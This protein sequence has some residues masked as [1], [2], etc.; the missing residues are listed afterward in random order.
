MSVKWTEGGATLSEDL[1]YRYSLDRVWDETRARLCWVM[2][3]PSTADGREDD[4][5][6]RKCMGFAD[7]WGYGSI[8]VVNLFAY[9]ATKPADLWR[10]SGTIDLVGPDNDR[11]IADA[12][13]K[14]KDVAVA[15]GGASHRIALQRIKS[16]C[17]GPLADTPL[18]CISENGDRSPTH[19]C[20]AGYKD[21]AG[22]GFRV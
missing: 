4:P 15:W 11:T 14:S 5:T 16:L 21:P 8:I 7:R 13:A 12:V 1:V 10:A 19:P 6:I 3:N 17:A 22:W 9:R 18:I 2:L 20:M